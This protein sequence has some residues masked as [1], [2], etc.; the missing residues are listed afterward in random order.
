M[1]AQTWLMSVNRVCTSHF[2]PAEKAKFQNQGPA[3]IYTA[4]L[5]EYED[6]MVEGVH[7]TSSAVNVSRTLS[8]LL[9]L[10]GAQDTVLNYENKACSAQVSRRIGTPYCK[11]CK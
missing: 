2:L 5:V 1:Q 6:D 10:D 3:Q 7:G 9:R 4:V 11:F 8:N